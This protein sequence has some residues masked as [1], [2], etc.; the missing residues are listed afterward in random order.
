[1]KAEFNFESSKIL[2]SRRSNRSI[3]VS[4]S[5]NLL[6][7]RFKYVRSIKYSEGKSNSNKKGYYLKKIGVKSNKARELNRG[8]FGQWDA[9]RRT[10]SSSSSLYKWWMCQ[11]PLR[12]RERA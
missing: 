1:M 11:D 3:N 4:N 7:Q 6:S 5:N 12:E 9:W 2:D 8:F 10:A